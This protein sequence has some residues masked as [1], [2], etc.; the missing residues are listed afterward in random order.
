VAQRERVFALFRRQL[1]VPLLDM[2]ATREEL[3]D[4]G[5]LEE[6]SQVE[7]GYKR[8]LKKLAEVTPFEERLVKI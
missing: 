4:W 5:T 8:A 2:E 6:Q 7:L 1:S 3:R